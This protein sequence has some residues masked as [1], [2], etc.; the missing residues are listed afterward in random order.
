MVEGEQIYGDGV[1]VAARLESLADPGGICISAKVHDEVAGKLEL[2]YQDLGPQRVKNIAE[3]L[4]V[5]RVLPGNGLQPST[6]RLGR[7]Y[8]RVG[9]SSAA[10]LAIIAVTIVLVQHLSL[11]PPRT[12]ASI[13]PI[14]KPALQLPD[15]PSIAV[16]PFTNL[17]G[18]PKQDYFS[19]GITD[20]LITDLSRLPG[21]M[22]IARNSTFI[23]EAK[24]VTVRQVGRELGVRGVLQGSVFKTTDRVRIAI[25]LADA[26]T[27]ANVWAARFDQPLTDIFTVEDDIVNKIV[28]TLNLMFKVNA[29]ALPP[30]RFRPTNNLKALTIGCAARN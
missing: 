20:Y 7:K 3:P 28:A 6:P 22:V 12:H 14:E 25:Q 11:R 17:N 29:L 2:A 30:G 1:N 5:W 23:Y 18:D 9:I 26:S 13:P 16:L 15:K 21:L 4:R 19:D 24:P 27:G 8:R 10:G